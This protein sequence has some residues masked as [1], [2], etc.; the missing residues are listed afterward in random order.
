MDLTEIDN[1]LGTTRSKLNSSE[2]VRDF[3]ESGELGREVDLNAGAFIGKT[4]S[5][6]KMA[7]DSARK[8]VSDETGQLVISG[9]TDVQVRVKQ[10]TNGK[11][12]KEKEVISERLFVINTRLVSEARAAQNGK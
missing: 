5:Q 6:V 2:Y 4:A 10:E 3:I 11:R 9:G 1:I 7:L 12:G 8:K